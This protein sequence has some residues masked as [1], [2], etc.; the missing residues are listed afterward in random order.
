MG[1]HGSVYAFNDNDT[2]SKFAHTKTVYGAALGIDQPNEQLGFAI[3]AGYM[4]DMTGVNDVAYGVGQFNGTTATGVGGSLVH[5]VGAF[6]LAGDVNSGPF[7]LAARYTAAIQSFSP[8]DLSNQYQVVTASGA[9]PWAADLT[10]KNANLGLE[11]G[12]DVAYSSGNGGTGRNSNTI[13]ARI[14]VKFG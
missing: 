4:S 5:R 7:S 14:G 1:F 13:G 11:V 9:R 8:A 12:H 3:N 10:W 6:A 2:V